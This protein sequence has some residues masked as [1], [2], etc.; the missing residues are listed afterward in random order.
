MGA[1]TVDLAAR[2]AENDYLAI[3]V[4]K[5]GVGS[6]LKQAVERELGNIRVICHDAVEVIRYMLPANSLDQVLIL[7]PDPWPKK[8]HHKRR[9]LSAGFLELL[10]P[11]MKMNA[12]MFL[13][14]DQEDLA[15]HMMEVCDN[16]PGL[17]NLAGKG[18]Y[19]PRPAWRKPT[20]F[21]NRGRKLDHPVWD[22]CY[23]PAC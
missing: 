21:E 22:L 6:L 7:F 13:A 5:P 16:H 12:C 15:V 4:H 8:K 3:E 9:L 17:I 2:F 14:T 23:C 11:R 1:T 10:I 19:A 18:H 20:K